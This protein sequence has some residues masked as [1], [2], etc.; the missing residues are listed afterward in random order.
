MSDVEVKKLYLKHEQEVTNAAAEQVRQ[1]FSKAWSKCASK[2]LPVENEELEKD[3]N[4][5]VFL[6]AAVK[7]YFPALYYDY[8]A[9]LAPLSVLTTTA[10]HLKFPTINVGDQSIEEREDAAEETSTRGD[11]AAAA[12]ADNGYASN[13]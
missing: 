4:K 12:G 2:A 8:G 11:S 13:E 1:W 3:L 7:R 5:D 6:E 9:F 10:L